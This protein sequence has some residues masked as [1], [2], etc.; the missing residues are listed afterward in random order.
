MAAQS[1]SIST[2]ASVLVVDDTP[3]VLTMMSS[4]L[5]GAGIRH[6]VTANC[7]QSALDKLP[8][9]DK[10]PFNAVFLDRYLGQECGHEVLKVIVAR[11]KASVPVI[12]LTKE[13]A[14]NKIIES[15]NLGARDYIVKPFNEETVITKLEQVLG[16]ELN[17]RL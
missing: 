5:L 14:A 2:D 11:Y 3:M 16:V 13:D 6:V 8:L 17:K 1:I 10:C 7:I 12:M 9:L 15:I 4:L